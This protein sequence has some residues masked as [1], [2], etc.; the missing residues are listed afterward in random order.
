MATTQ[1]EHRFY[2]HSLQVT[3]LVDFQVVVKETDLH[4]H[5]LRDL[6]GIA[7]ETVIEIRGYLES[8]ISQHPQFAETLIPWHL[9]GP[10]PSIIRDMARAGAFAGVGPMAAVAGAIAAHV[11]K[12]LLAHSTEV[13]VENGGDVFMATARP[14]TMGIYAGRS[15]LSLRLGLKIGG[16]NEPVSVCTSSGTVGH[17]LSTGRADAVCIVSKDC[18]LADA[19]AT[20]TGNRVRD[21]TDIQK[22]I[23]Y[24]QTVSGVE[25]LVVIIGD[26]MGVWGDVELVPLERNL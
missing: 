16:Q 25:G 20:A 8:Y 18:A 12:D 3:G 26:Q 2:R 7:R 23:E 6:A 17:S 14:I 9:S 11:G 1:H 4:I 13:I 19:A 5:A 10:A 21:A 24:S 15:P 22:A